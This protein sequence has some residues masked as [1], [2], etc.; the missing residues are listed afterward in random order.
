MVL[1]EVVE[2]DLPIFFDNQ[3]DPEAVRMAAWPARE[4]D[5]YMHHWRTNIFGDPSVIQRTI[6]AN[7]GG[8]RREGNVGAWTRDG[9][10]MIGYW[11]GRA[12]W[13]RGL[14]T[15]ALAELIEK[16][17]PVRPLYAEVAVANVGSVRVLF[18][19]VR[20]RPGR[21]G[22]DGRGRRARAHDASGRLEGETV[23][24]VKAPWRSRSS[25][26]SARRAASAV[27]VS[28][29]RCP[30]TDQASPAASYS[31]SLPEEL[32]PPESIASA[33]SRT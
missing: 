18:R 14:A 15:A 12:H 7:G 21:P 33:R 32:V 4:L 28:A 27:R 9:R 25:P 31:Q 30:T 2:D 23:A 20:V 8:R 22:D 6:V 11:L 17:E 13:G 1:R 3:R 26:R 24:F 10:R 29:V 5:A 16:H 19:E